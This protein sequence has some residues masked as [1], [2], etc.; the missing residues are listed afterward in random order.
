MEFQREDLVDNGSYMS[1]VAAG[2]VDYFSGSYMEE[3]IEH[4]FYFMVNVT[5]ERVLELDGPVSKDIPFS[6]K[7][8]EFLKQFAK[9]IF[10]AIQTENIVSSLNAG[11]LKENFRRNRTFFSNGSI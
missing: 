2:M 4:N 9:V 8:D 3:F 7:Y 11:V 1:L 10:P 5:G 6:D